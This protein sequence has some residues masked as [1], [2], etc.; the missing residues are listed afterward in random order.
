MGHEVREN[1]KHGTSTSG[2]Y[3]YCSS[4][5]SHSHKQLTRKTQSVLGARVRTLKGKARPVGQTAF[6][7]SCG[8]V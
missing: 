6:F 3:L 8:Y 7:V 2:W 1:V 5:C 4:C